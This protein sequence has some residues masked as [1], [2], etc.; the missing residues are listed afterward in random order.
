MTSPI[1]RFV[2]DLKRAPRLGER[3]VHHESL[4]ARPPSFAEQNRPLPESL[5]ALLRGQGIEQLYSHQAQ[6]ID[7]VRSG[8]HTVVATPTASGKSLVYCLPVL[9]SFLQDPG[10]SSLFLFPLKALARDQ[11]RTLTELVGPWPEADRPSMAVFDG[12]TPSRERTRIRK[13]PPNILLTNPEMLHLSILPGFEPW[14][15]FLRRLK[16]VVVDEVHTCR[17]VM[18]S[19]M[20]WV[21]RRL[22]RICRYIGADPTFIFCS[23][24]VGN[25]GWLA[26]ELTGLEVEAVT[27]TGSPQGARN[28]VFINPLDGAAQSA[29]LLLQSALTRGL[30]TIV[31]TQSRKMTELLAMWA[32]KRC[33]KQ[34]GRISAYRSGFLPE[35]RRT[36]E[37]KLSRGDLLAVIST[38]ALELGIDIG[39]L[40]LCI[41]VGY[42]GSVMAT[43]QRGGR[44]GRSQQDSAVV[45]VG[46]EDN[47]DQYFMHHPEQFF[48][49]PPEDA[50][51]NPFNPVLLSRHLQCAAADL[52]LDR[53]EPL[54]AD[55]R[56]SSSVDR[57][58]EQSLLLGSAGGG[59]YYAASKDVHRQV[60][61]RGTGRSLQIMD[62]SSGKSIG[63]V[64]YYR[65]LHETHPG[66]VYLHRGRTYLIEELQLE[67]NT[68]L[69]SEREVDYFTRVRSD[70]QTE[71]LSRE[72]W[73]MAG[74]VRVS[75][76][77]LRITERITGFE[78]RRVRG[79]K[80][81]SVEPL[82]IDPLIFE[83]EGIWLDIPEAL[84]REAEE[85][86]MHFM[87]GIH[88]LEHAMIGIMPLVILTDRSDLGGISQPWQPQLGSA[89][90]FVFD[91]VPGGVG[92]SRQAYLRAEELLQRTREAV[93]S[94]D[95]E[96]GCPACVHSPK[97]GS[98]NRPLDKKAAVMLLDRLLAEE[99]AELAGGPAPIEEAASAVP[100]PD[101][102]PGPAIRT[103]RSRPGN[104]GVLDVETK[105]SA[106]QVGGWSKAER[107]GLS[108]GVLYDSSSD[109][110][111]VY[112]EDQVEAL[113][114]RLQ[115]L[116]LVVGFNLLGFDY[117]VLSAYN[118]LDWSGLPTL[119]L[120]LEVRKRLGYRLSLDHLASATLGAA[121][122]G[123][124]LQALTWYQRG[125][126]DKLA[127]YCR[128]DVALTRDLYLF[129]RDEGYLLFTNKAKELV[130][131]S[132]DW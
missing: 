8:R 64:D 10:S 59:R 7:R 71:V 77:R 132:V 86:M 52:P 126:M 104:F 74:G 103:S 127:E 70:K 107:M 116:D 112:T 128:Q 62:Q 80:L 131:I 123:S 125:E 34:A 4:Q 118:Q 53:D 122:G 79:R 109:S 119:D 33:R 67:N 68:V 11:L 85:R 69:A 81:L 3:V 76:G 129:G 61:L 35:E 73:R 100:E 58:Y 97:C 99:T 14:Q 82:D 101:P 43:W 93:T 66:A 115:R 18:G 130:R 75:L 9:E 90:V 63:S 92:L 91:S 51:I 110:F 95:C 32:A 48:R 25:P 29:L 55:S 19:N 78:R 38:S 120:L 40:D 98:G 42:P 22:L 108:L 31:Y 111:E 106:S 2:Q 72:A 113:V 57:L 39:S 6:A 16:Y 26:S 114:D 13:Q 87:G 124:G 96:L 46:H 37:A 50:V 83:T 54:L 44:V 102:E 105:R 56:V 12:D 23:A 121:K 28:V 17:G 15:E 24:T 84:H 65:A 49:L 30:R 60:N 88:A 21:F 20:A 36:I 41:L 27:E 117:K 94:C 89:A 45:L 47:L 5:Q 1:E